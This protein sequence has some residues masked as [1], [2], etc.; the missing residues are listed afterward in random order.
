MLGLLTALAVGMV[1][2]FERVL[3]NERRSLDQQLLEAREHFERD[4]RERIADAPVDGEAE[5]VAWAMRRFIELEPASVDVVTVAWAGE[6]RVG[7]TALDVETREIID[8]GRFDSLVMGRLGTVH[9]SVGDLRAMRVDVLDG[10]DRVG[11]FAVAGPLASARSEAF[12]ALGRLA[13]AALVS[14]LVGWLVV[15]IAVRRVLR[16]LLRLTTAAASTEMNRFAGAVVVEGNDEVADLT[17]EFNAMIARLDD[18]S[19]ERERLLATISHELRTPLAVARA[20]LE[21]AEFAH[22]DTAARD[23]AA[24]GTDDVGESLAVARDELERMSRLVGDL[25]AL[26]RS[27]R[28]GFL[29]RREVRL[30]DL[31]RDLELRLDGLGFDTVTVAP[32][33]EAI[34]VVDAERILQALL[35]CVQN[36]V[37]HNPAG[38]TVDVSIGIVSDRLVIRVVDDG[39]GIPPEHRAEV[40]EPFV[41]FDRGTGHASQSSGLGLAVVV[42]IADAHGGLVR[43]LDAPAGV[44][45]PAGGTGTTVEISFPVEWSAID[46]RLP[47]GTASQPPGSRAG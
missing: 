7:S 21:L 31:A 38:T 14:L 42:A 46:A 28:S 16:P 44:E 47:S 12:E 40:L 43:I 25:L 6:E 26:G 32:P 10:T 39:T 20:K 17:R 34:V 36:G 8:E 13:L 30:D 27:G 2:T 4:M 19:A 45:V 33:P 1:L 3:A 35:N 18:A 22:R 11:S 37:V 23:T 29:Q 15:E 41:S 9:T 24:R 5:R